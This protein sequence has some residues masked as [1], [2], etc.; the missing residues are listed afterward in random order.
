[1]AMVASAGIPP[2]HA[3]GAGT[4]EA[5]EGE[6]RREGCR[7]PAQSQGLFH[8]MPEEKRFSLDRRFL[9]GT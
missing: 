5:S 7:V 4:K 8:E 9:L 2:P 6:K 1:M 3:C